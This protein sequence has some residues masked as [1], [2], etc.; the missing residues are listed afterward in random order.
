MTR[1]RLAA[2]LALGCLWLPG[3]SGS[4]ER[5]SYPISIAVSPAGDAAVVGNA[6]R[7]SELLTLPELQ[8]QRFL[9]A[10]KG[11][12]ARWHPSAPRVALFSDQLWV[13]STEPWRLVHHTAQ[14]LV[15][16]AFHAERPL[17]VAL[18]KTGEASHGVLLLDLVTNPTPL[19]FPIPDRHPNRIAYVG[20]DQVLILGSDGAASLWSLSSRQELARTRVE[21]MTGP[22]DVD[23]RA[24]SRLAAWISQDTGRAGLLSVPE[25]G[26]VLSIAAHRPRDAEVVRLHP[27]RRAVVTGAGYPDSSLKLWDA[28]TG[29]LLGRQ[30]GWQVLDVGFSPDGETLYVCDRQREAPR[31]LALAELLGG[32]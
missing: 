29:E 10:Q 18:Q 3:P 32:R 26:S 24:Q 21:G 11:A 31:K 8:R 27:T 19:L 16:I 12:Y 4:A 14:P 17:L 25:L 28:E 23:A 13:Y 9:E 7:A 1:L 5:R 15:D 30:G 22:L 2:A 20:E 6:E